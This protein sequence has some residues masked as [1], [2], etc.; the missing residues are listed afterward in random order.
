VA[1]LENCVL[2]LLL[3]VSAL[4]KRRWRD[5]PNCSETPAERQVLGEV[6]AI[7]S[8]AQCQELD[9][10]EC[11]MYLLNMQSGNHGILDDVVT[12]NRGRILLK[13]RLQSPLISHKPPRVSAE[14]D[15]VKRASV[16]LIMTVWRE[17]N[18]ASSLSGSGGTPV[19]HNKQECF[20]KA[21]FFPSR[22]LNKQHNSTE[23]RPPGLP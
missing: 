19:V 22:G 1:V 6:R 23:P 20:A 18:S 16:S 17:D 15:G 4:F 12:P 13:L 9:V 3:G 14:I 5:S 7:S 21:R 11:F 8:D 2:R 10:V